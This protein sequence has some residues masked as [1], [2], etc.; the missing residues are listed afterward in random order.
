MVRLKKFIQFIK[1]LFGTKEDLSVSNPVDVEVKEQKKPDIKKTKEVAHRCVI[2]KTENFG[3]I[4]IFNDG[5]D[6]EPAEDIDC[7]TVI[8]PFV[9]FHKWYMSGRTSKFQ[10]D[11][12][13]GN[14]CYVFLRD[15]IT[16]IR[17]Y[18]KTVTAE[19]DIKQPNIDK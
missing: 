13:H 3:E 7:I 4:E 1:F 6:D 16:G 11:L 17:Y 9:E 5:Q 19:D 14:S 2:I 18:T 15:Q 8:K 10:F 12:Q